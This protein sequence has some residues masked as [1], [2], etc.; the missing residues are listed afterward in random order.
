MKFWTAPALTPQDWLD[1]ARRSF[2]WLLAEARPEAPRMLS[3][4]LH[5]RI[6]GRPGRIWALEAFLDHVAA[7]EGVWITTRRA[8]AER[9]AACCPWTG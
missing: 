7:A 1:Y 3:V 9:F 8:I 4:G 6:I 5:L 2:D